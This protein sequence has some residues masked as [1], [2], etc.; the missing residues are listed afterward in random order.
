MIKRIFGGVL[1]LLM[2][3]LAAAQINA[4]VSILPLK[5]FVDRIGGDQVNVSVMVGPGQSPETYA[6]TPKQMVMLSKTKIYYRIGVP[7]ENAWIGKIAK[8]NPNM[9]IVDLRSGISMLKKGDPHIWTNPILVIKIAKTIRNS[10]EQIDP[11]N[12]KTYEKNYAAFK[13]DLKK[14]DNYIGKTVSPCGFV[15][16]HPAWGYFA[17]R[18]GLTQIAL[19]QEGKEPGPKD[20]ERVIN[21]AKK[22][23]IKL[24][25]VQ[26]QFSEVQ[27][28]MIANT[29]DAKIVILDPL[30]EDY[31]NNMRKVANVFGNYA[32]K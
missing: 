15:V 4:F 2:P 8:T 12:K 7:F 29:I 17:H 13:K 16:F 25:I 26:P 19:E 11:N 10:L 9:P 32:R 3:I 6:P 1:I 30:V 22:Q 5:Y 20:I 28:K 18:Y 23:H 24:V 27:A 31:L 21:T 14:L